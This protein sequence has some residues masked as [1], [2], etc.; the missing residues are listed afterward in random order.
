[1]IQSHLICTFANRDNSK[2]ILQTIRTTYSL[3][4]NY[5]YI[6]QNKSNLDELYVT[7]NIDAEIIP[8][9]PLIN[10]ISIH[11]KKESNTIYTINALNILIASKNNGIQDKSYILDWDN[12]KNSIILTNSTDVRIVST[13]LYDIIALENGRL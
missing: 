12:Y 1:M 2:S 6:L 3:V 13:Q 10:T 11:R 9:T 4:Y 7:Y 5:M 8:K